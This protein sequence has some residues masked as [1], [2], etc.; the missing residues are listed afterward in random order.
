MRK[1][2]KSLNRRT[3]QKLLLIL[4]KVDKGE[5][6]GVEK[7]TFDRGQV[8]PVGK[9]RHNKIYIYIYNFFIFLIFF[10]LLNNLTV[11]FQTKL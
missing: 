7:P 9:S 6:A 11:M 4:I 10:I 1:N 2:L 8:E 5:G 3:K